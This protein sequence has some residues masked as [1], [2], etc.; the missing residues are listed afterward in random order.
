MATKRREFQDALADVCTLNE[1]TSS[2]QIDIG[3][4]IAARVSCWHEYLM[5][6]VIKLYCV[7]VL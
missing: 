6:F 3:R 1:C 5:R 4:F 2:L 7:V